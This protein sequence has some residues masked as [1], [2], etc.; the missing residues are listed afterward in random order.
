MVKVIYGEYDAVVYYLGVK[1][2]SP[3]VSFAKNLLQVNYNTMDVSGEKKLQSCNWGRKKT[4]SLYTHTHTHIR[5][6]M[7]AHTFIHTHTRATHT[8]RTAAA[9]RKA[10]MA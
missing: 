2:L 3:R 10:K 6:N 5:I 4:H 7:R 9:D 1:L 8:R